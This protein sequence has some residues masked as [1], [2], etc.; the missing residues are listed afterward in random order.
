M[1]KVRIYNS[2]ST[3][4]ILTLRAGE[5]LKYDQVCRSVVFAPNLERIRHFHHLLVPDGYEQNYVRV[6]NDFSDLAEK[7]MEL[8]HDPPLA[9]HIADNNVRTLREWYGTSAAD[10]CYW[11]ALFDGYSLV[12]SSHD[13]ADD[14]GPP[15]GLQYEFFILLE[16]R[17][18]LYFNFPRG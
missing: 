2:G 1:S 9:E 17:S 11:R 4:I 18:M 3:W 7:I 14:D 13:I 12:F 5:S 16:S 15:R 8:I 10:A 6:E